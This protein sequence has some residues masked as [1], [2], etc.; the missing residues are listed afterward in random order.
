MYVLQFSSILVYAG[1]TFEEF[2]ISFVHNSLYRRVENFEF[3]LNF[4]LLH[5]ELLAKIVLY[6]KG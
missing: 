5:S 1:E 2:I 4:I 3:P 6:C